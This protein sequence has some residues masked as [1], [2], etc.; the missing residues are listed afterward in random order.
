MAVRLRLRRMGRKKRPFYRLVVADQRSP[1]DGRFIEVVGFYDPLQKPYQLELKENRITYWLE[2]G[3]QPSTTVKSLLRRHGIWYKH[4]LQKRGLEAE[5]IEEEMKK[6]DLLQI[7]RR[8]RQEVA[9]LEKARKKA[10]KKEAE[11]EE[12]PEEKSVKKTETVEADTENRAAEVKSEESEKEIVETAEAE[13]EEKDVSG[14]E[15]VE[16]Q[17]VEEKTEEN[18]EKTDQK[19]AE[20]DQTTEVESDEE[21]KDEKNKQN[22]KKE[23]GNVSSDEKTDTSENTVEAESKDEK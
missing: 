7:E 9:A 17:P 12:Q 14:A 11:K 16:E 15:I 6:W 8:K 23:L 5:K 20:G 2:N 22:V 13:G 21:I 10:A 3:A 19:T 1:R 4:D 18:S